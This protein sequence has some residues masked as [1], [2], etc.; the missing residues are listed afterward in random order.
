[1]MNVAEMSGALQGIAEFSAFVHI[2]VLEL[3]ES[4]EDEK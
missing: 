4:L 3:P 1:M 2:D